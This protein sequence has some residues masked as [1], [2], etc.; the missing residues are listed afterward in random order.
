[1]FGTTQFGASAYAKVGIETGVASASPHKLIVMLY[2]GAAVS[3][4]SALMHMKAGQIAEKG[5]A[6]SKTIMIIDGGLRT[7]L[8]KTAGGEIAE[9][10]DG[11]YQYMTARLVEANLK[12]K[13][14]ILEEVYKLLLELKGAWD[15]IAET[16]SPP[17]VEQMPVKVPVYD[18]LAPRSSSLGRA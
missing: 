11:L 1:M 16:V 7:S 10:L 13:P 18:T 17:V 2:E 12:N 9:N 4:S 8:D 6:I 5:K 14:E 3:L 15:A